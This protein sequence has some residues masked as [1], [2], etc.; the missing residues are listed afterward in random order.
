M[1]IKRIDSSTVMVDDVC[2]EYNEKSASYLTFSG[3]CTDRHWNSLNRFLRNENEKVKAEY[4]EYFKFFRH[5]NE[6]LN[7]IGICSVQL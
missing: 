3:K 6:I 1:I 4:D 5:L 7:E 2:F